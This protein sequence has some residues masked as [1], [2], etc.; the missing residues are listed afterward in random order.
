M[1]LGFTGTREGMTPNQLARLRLYLARLNPK[2]F[3][4]G[5]AVGADEQA[6]LEAL[7][8]ILARNIEIFPGSRKRE[9]FWRGCFPRPYIASWT[10]PLMRN[11]FITKR[12]NHLIACSATEEEVT[13]SG[14]WATVRYARQAFRPITIIAPSGIVKEEYPVYETKVKKE[15]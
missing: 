8:F 2:V 7:K 12:C 9:I 13:R 4:H 11:R 14:T 1:I 5:G 6:H 3:I 10:Q 15:A